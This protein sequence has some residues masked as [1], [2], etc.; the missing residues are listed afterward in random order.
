MYRETDLRIQQTFYMMFTK[1]DNN[2]GVFFHIVKV[3]IVNPDLRITLKCLKK[4]YGNI[5]VFFKLI[6]YWGIVALQ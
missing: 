5:C 1:P 6:F 3:Q 2:G 4:N